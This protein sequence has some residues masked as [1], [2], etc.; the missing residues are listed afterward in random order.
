MIDPPNGEGR[1]LSTIWLSAHG[2]LIYVID[3]ITIIHEPGM[4][5]SMGTGTVA[6]E[7]S[8]SFY[9]SYGS[10]KTH[11]LNPAIQLSP[12]EQRP[13]SFTIGLAPTGTFSSVGGRVSATLNYHAS[14]GR[15]G[16]LTLREPPADAVLVGRLLAVPV[17]SGGMLVGPNGAQ[18]G[19]DEGDAG[20]LEYSRLQFPRQFLWD[21][22]D[23]LAY[24]EISGMKSR[25]AL[26]TALK[27]QGWI[28]QIAQQASAGKEPYVDLCA[29]IDDSL[30]ES[31]LLEAA[32]LDSR[33]P[34]AAAALSV[35]HLIYPSERLAEFALQNSARLATILVQ[36]NREVGRNVF[37][38][39]TWKEQVLENLLVAL[40][41]KPQGP[42]A[43]ALLALAAR[44]NYHAVTALF[45]SLSELDQ[46]AKARLQEITW[47][48]LAWGWPADVSVK[49]LLSLGVPAPE[50]AERL[51]RLP[52]TIPE[53]RP[54]LTEAR[55]ND[56]RRQIAQAILKGD[57]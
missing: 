22:A 40:I 20:H 39:D 37:E 56:R 35:R 23:N 1:S 6:P 14:D 15:R 10:W 49:T 42:W 2:D 26:N 18:L 36:E 31:A 12:S 13:V 51:G 47:D 52:I 57:F 38:V 17:R 55:I 54:D 28:A 50:V 34:V 32:T 24:N 30:C 29:A 19:L 7:A 21:A 46:H 45:A 41:L 25:Q 3:S 27:Q 43:N 4:A 48:N 9:F 5:A 33:L 16:T 11:A 44:R 8:Y 53:E